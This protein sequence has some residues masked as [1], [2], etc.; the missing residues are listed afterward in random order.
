MHAVRLGVEG[1]ECAPLCANFISL[2]YLKAW[3]TLLGLEPVSS[4]LMA[5][6]PQVS[7]GDGVRRLGFIKNVSADGGRGRLLYY[8]IDA[9][10]RHHNMCLI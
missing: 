8:G 7:C 6:A 3:L 4:G 10:R 9:I 1:D 5:Y 2:A